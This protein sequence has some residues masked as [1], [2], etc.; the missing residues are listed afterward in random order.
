MRTLVAS[1]RLAVKFLVLCCS[2]DFIKLVTFFHF[3]PKYDHAL[4]AQ[5][6]ETIIKPES[7]GSRSC[8][9]VKT[10]IYCFCKD[11]TICCE[12]CLINC[13]QTLSENIMSGEAAQVN[14]EHSEP[15]VK[16]LIHLSCCWWM[17]C[18]HMFCFEG[19]LESSSSLF[20]CFFSAHL[21]PQS[22]PGSFSLSL[23]SVAELLRLKVKW[24]SEAVMA[25]YRALPILSMCFSLQIGE[26]V[27]SHRGTPIQTSEQLTCSS[28]CSLSCV[29]A[30]VFKQQ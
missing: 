29:F 22:A 16:G 30:C 24:I 13:V 23:S 1:S 6:V 10:H 25:H 21:N 11:A 9:G 19:N 14:T 2:W 4:Q 28:C 17:A 20:L 27:G 18:S 5:T 3:S 15:P 8:F 12:C 7:S 26:V